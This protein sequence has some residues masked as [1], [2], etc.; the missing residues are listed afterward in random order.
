[1]LAGN[2][3]RGGERGPGRRRRW[4]KI[5]SQQFAYVFMSGAV[6]RGSVSHH[7][8]TVDVDGLASHVVGVAAGQKADHPREIVGLLG[9]AEW[10]VGDAALPGLTELPALDL[11]PV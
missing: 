1:R 10:N 11:G 3:L 9:A 5:R 4:R 2:E 6:S 8:A 7:D